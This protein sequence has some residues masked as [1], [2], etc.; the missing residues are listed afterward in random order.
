M[1]GCLENNC[2]VG[3]AKTFTR[4]LA[5]PP[6]PP[7]PPLLPPPPPL[8]LLS[9]ICS[10]MQKISSF[11]QLIVETQSILES[12]D[13][14]GHTHLWPRPTQ[15]FWLTFNLCQFVSTGKN[16][17]YFTDLFWEHFCPYLRNKNFPKYRICAGTQQII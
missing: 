17:G 15:K 7:P 9:W 14:T 10:S 3:L 13:Q 16:S 12:C 8:L 1:I 4:I 11:H 6:P 5:P 2:Q